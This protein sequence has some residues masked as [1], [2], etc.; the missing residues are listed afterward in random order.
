[1][2]PINIF[3]LFSLTASI[4]VLEQTLMGAFRTKRLFNQ[5]WWNRCF[6]PLK[7]FSFSLFNNI[8]CARRW[9]EDVR[10]NEYKCVLLHC[11]AW[12][13]MIIIIWRTSCLFASTSR[14]ICKSAPVRWLICFKTTSLIE[15]HDFQ[16][17]NW[18][19]I[20]IRINAMFG[21]AYFL[22]IYICIY[23]SLT[24]MIKL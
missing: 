17:V 19:Y 3:A 24:V 8:T 11:K 22:Y 6:L 4:D 20:K 15:L 9:D 21:K 12:V 14:I 16:F 2:Q 18:Y 1:M 10:S 23:N 7:A 13:P 5:Q